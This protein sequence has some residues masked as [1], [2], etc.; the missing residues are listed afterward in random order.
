VRGVQRLVRALQQLRDHERGIGG[1]HRE[2]SRAEP[3]RRC[4]RRQQSSERDAAERR[5]RQRSGLPWQAATIGPREREQRRDEQRAHRT[6]SGR[7]PSERER[8]QHRHG[9]ERQV[10]KCLSAGRFGRAGDH[11]EADHGQRRDH[12]PAARAQPSERRGRERASQAH[13]HALSKRQQRDRYPER[14]HRSNIDSP[15]RA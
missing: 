15:L 11:D 10:R 12:G 1:G 3:A 2:D 13:D 8:S 7:E 9:D 5:Q 14:E 6:R 4:H